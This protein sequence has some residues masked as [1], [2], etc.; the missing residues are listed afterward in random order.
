MC[1]LLISLLI[2]TASVSCSKNEKG[3]PPAVI[4]DMINGIIL[5]LHVTPLNITKPDK[6][7][8]TIFMTGTIY[9]AE[10]NAVPQSQSNAV[11]SFESDTILVAESREFANL[12]KDAVAYNPVAA[13]E[14]TIRFNN[15]KKILGRFDLNT[16][17][18]GDF[19]ETLISQWR[20]PNDPAKPNQKAKD[21]LS[22]FVKLYSDADGPGPGVSPLYLLVQVSKQ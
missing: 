13:N 21:D 19:G 11:L 2:L 17:F 14:V 18:G 15:G 1:R 22:R 7:S 12:G 20:N 5:D 4:P 9:K 3:L 10:F 16:G 6:G 8:F